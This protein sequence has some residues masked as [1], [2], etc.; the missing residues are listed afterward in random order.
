MTKFFFRYILITLTLVLC[1]G[2]GSAQTAPISLND[3]IG[4]GLPVVEVWTENEQEPTCDIIYAPE[5]LT[6]I[7]ITNDI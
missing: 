2:K 4:K 7:S 6:G 3:I 5:G 1:Q